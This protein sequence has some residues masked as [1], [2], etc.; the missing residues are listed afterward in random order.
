[1]DVTGWSAL[2]PRGV[3]QKTV[4]MPDGRAEEGGCH[5]EEGGGARCSSQCCRH[6][7]MDRVQ[8]QW[9]STRLPIC[10][11]LA[12]S[13]TTVGSSHWYQATRRVAKPLCQGFP[14]DLPCIHFNR[15]SRRDNGSQ[16]VQYIWETEDDKFIQR[17]FHMALWQSCQ[18]SLSST[19]ECGPQVLGVTG[20][21]RGHEQEL[22]SQAAW[23]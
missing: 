10:L 20:A 5:E 21:G 19:G 15:D 16:A 8:R 23:V 17:R 12:F 7:A 1:M 2:I 4:R 9:V 13:L 14:G 22:W 18:E 11:A 3:R 6:A